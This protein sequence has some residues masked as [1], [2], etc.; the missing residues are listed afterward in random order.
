MKQKLPLLLSI[1]AI[2]LLILNKLFGIKHDSTL[3]NVLTLVSFAVIIILNITAIY[4]MKKNFYQVI[5]IILVILLFLMLIY[6]IF[7]SLILFVIGP[8]T[9]INEY[10]FP[11]NSNETLKNIYYKDMSKVTPPIHVIYEK[12]LLLGIKCSIVIKSNTESTE[13]FD[14]EEIYNTELKNAKNLGFCNYK[15]KYD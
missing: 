5:N 13:I 12:E 11:S 7:T 2:I 8:T 3:I 14:L 4:K 15:I 9:V 10:T 6:K 1:L